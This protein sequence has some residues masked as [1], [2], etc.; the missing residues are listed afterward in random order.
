VMDLSQELAS[1][2]VISVV[3]PAAMITIIGFSLLLAYYLLG[4]NSSPANLEQVNSADPAPDD[5]WD[6]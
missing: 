5:M 3:I 6:A 2:L 1:R 4:R